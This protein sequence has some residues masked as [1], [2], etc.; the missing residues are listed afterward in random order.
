MKKSIHTIP[1]PFKLFH[2][3]F[4]LLFGWINFMYPQQGGL[5]LIL[6]SSVPRMVSLPMKS[7]KFTKTGK[8]SCG[9]P[10]ETGFACMTGNG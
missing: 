3:V 6:I 7:R 4:I 1:A 9:L 8:D 2:A 5:I 10:R